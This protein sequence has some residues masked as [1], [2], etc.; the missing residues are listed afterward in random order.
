MD[1]GWLWDRKISLSKVKSIFKNESHPRFV[2]FAG[3]LLARKNIPKEIFKEYLSPLV[4]CRNW[5]RIKKRMRMDNWNNPRIEFWQAIYEN[6]I[7]KYKKKNIIPKPIK[8]NAQPANELSYEIAQKIINMRKQKGFTQGDLA[9]KSKV[10]Q[11]MI[12]RI[13]NGRQNLSIATMKK[14]ADS[15]GCKVNVE[16]MSKK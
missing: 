1:R 2:E 9:K 5:Q 8:A 7:K 11:Q 10:S 12:S 14:I 6:L 4:F 16:L 13:E 3:L 15:L